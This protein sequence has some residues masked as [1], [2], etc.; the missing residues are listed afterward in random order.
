MANLLGQNDIMER[1]HVGKNK[2]YALLKSPGFPAFRIG[3]NY[4]VNEDDL[5]RWEKT[6]IGKEV[7]LNAQT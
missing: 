7:R 6:M 4:L 3:R 5:Y 2:A 1:Y